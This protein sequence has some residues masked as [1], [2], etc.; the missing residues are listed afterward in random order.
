MPAA[1]SGIAPTDSSSASRAW[2][3]A[4]RRCPNRRSQR[5]SIHAAAPADE[6]EP[7]RSVR[8]VSARVAS[9]AS[10]AASTACSASIAHSAAKRSTPSRANTCE[11]ANARRHDGN[12]SERGAPA[13]ARAWA[14]WHR[15]VGRF[16]WACAS[17]VCWYSCASSWR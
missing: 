8:S 7:E 1:S 3:S 16:V 11:S 13:I 9:R 5:A 6:R 4:R 12:T 10:S 2:S 17:I 14:M 15:T